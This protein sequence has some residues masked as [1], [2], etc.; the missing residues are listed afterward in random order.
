V[1]SPLVAAGKLVVLASC[2]TERMPWV[3][4]A[5]TVASVTGQEYDMSTW[6]ALFAPTGTP[7]EILDFLNQEVRTTMSKETVQKAALDQGFKA[8]PHMARKDVAAFV[9]NDS[10]RWG[11]YIEAAGVERQ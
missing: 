7:T 10:A 9:A 4:S 11:R 3:P 8:Y 6:H 1:L 5:P 2:G